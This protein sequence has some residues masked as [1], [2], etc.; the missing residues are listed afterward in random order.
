VEKLVNNPKSSKILGN[1]FLFAG[2]IP[3]VLW[4]LDYID[5]VRPEADP[6][7]WGVL[8]MSAALI[9]LGTLLIKGEGDSIVEVFAN[10]KNKLG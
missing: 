7:A 5:V 4:I 1:I 3:I 6:T 9:S 8:V 10:I 2:V